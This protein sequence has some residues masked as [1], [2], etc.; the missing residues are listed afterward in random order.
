[1]T[2]AERSRILL[3]LNSDHGDIDHDDIDHA[4]R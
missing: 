1:M 3:N 4:I 2:M